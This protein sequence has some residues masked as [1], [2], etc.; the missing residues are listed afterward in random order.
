MASEEFQQE[1]AAIDDGDGVDFIFSMPPEGFFGV[2]STSK[3]ID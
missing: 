2:R 3:P 1:K